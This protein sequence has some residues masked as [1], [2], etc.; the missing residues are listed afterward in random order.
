MTRKTLYLL[1]VLILTTSCGG[2]GGGGGSGDE[3][4]PP[5]APADDLLSA[6][7][8]GAT[9]LAVLAND[10]G[11]PA[12]VDLSLVTLPKKGTA[13]VETDG[14]VR[15]TPEDGFNGTDSFTYFADDGRAS[16]QATVHVTVY[17]SLTGAAPIVMLPRLSIEAEELAV[18]VNDQDAQSTAVAD[19]YVLKRNIPAKNVIHL[20]FTPGGAGLTE[21][22]FAALF[23]EVQAKL[24]PEIQALAITWTRPYKVL[25]MS[26][27]SAF[28]L[29]FSTDWYATEAGCNPTS[30]S[31]FYDSASRRPFDDHGIRPAM[32]LAG[33]TTDDVLDLIDRGVA[34]DG[35]FPTGTAWLVRTTDGARSSRYPLMIEAEAEWDHAPDGLTVIY[36][37]Q[38]EGNLITNTAGILVYL[39]GLT[40]VGELDTNTYHPGAIG[41]HLTSYGGVLGGTSQMDVIQW[42]KAGLTGSF[43]TVQEPC[44]YTAKFP[45]PVPLLSHY[46]RGNT[47]IEAYWKSV[48]WP[49][50]GLFVGEPLASPFG[51]FFLEY[52]DG[53]VRIRT[54]SLA[55]G[56]QYRVVAAD[57]PAGPFTTVL[58]GISIPHHR[59][60]TI[61]LPAADRAVYRLEADD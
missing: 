46:Y 28:T 34:A 30:P 17:A 47:L 25:G 32:M 14:R 38:P 36:E 39:T 55:P 50:E 8:S 7:E 48:Q 45:D 33:E 26:I 6:T 27:T 54:T 49:G 44:N 4:K 40:W 58:D 31:G 9:L 61:T 52:E 41:D 24:T 20:S 11:D 22:A 13:T 18:L 2:G 56:E 3:P 60:E 29:G 23:A 15:Y 51:R 35:T 59:L 57:T 16:G 12:D 21:S 37:D 19:Y 53:T 42:L 10:G 43:G 5:I 1:L